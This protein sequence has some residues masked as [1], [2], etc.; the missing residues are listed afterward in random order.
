MFVNMLGD[1]H[2]LE[3]AVVLGDF[4]HF[5]KCLCYGISQL[6]VKFYCVEFI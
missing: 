5:L 6:K 2:F 3:S 1:V 4:L